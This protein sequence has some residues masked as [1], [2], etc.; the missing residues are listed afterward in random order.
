MRRCRCRCRC[1]LL[2][3]RPASSLHSSIF[4]SLCKKFVV[5]IRNFDAWLDSC[6]WAGW[7][8]DLADLAE[9]VDL[10]ELGVGQGLLDDG[11]ASFWRLNFDAPT[12]Y[13]IVFLAFTRQNYGSAAVA[14]PPTVQ[15]PT[16]SSGRSW[17]LCKNRKL[18]AQMAP[19]PCPVAGPWLRHAVR[20]SSLEFIFIVLRNFQLLQLYQYM[21]IDAHSPLP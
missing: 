4:I 12:V 5:C 21:N 10:A 9:L 2:P 1:L 3:R 14:N 7:L 13:S 15:P 16:A 6:Q 17:G 20:P 8:A 11:F 19:R 18:L